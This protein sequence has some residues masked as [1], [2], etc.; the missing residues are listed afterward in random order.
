MG[1]HHIRSLVSLAELSLATLLTG[2]RLGILVS[3]HTEAPKPESPRFPTRHCS[4][5]SPNA[6]S[7]PPSRRPTSLP[8][9]RPPARPALGD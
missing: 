2:L 9:L 8:S 4:R 3:H 7:P 5:V 6:S 1:S